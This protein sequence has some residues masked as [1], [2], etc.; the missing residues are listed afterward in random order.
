MSI[1]FKNCRF[2]KCLFNNS[3]VFVSLIMGISNDNGVIC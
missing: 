2:V 1:V 3:V